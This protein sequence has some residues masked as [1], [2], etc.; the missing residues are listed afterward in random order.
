MDKNARLKWSGVA[1][2]ASSKSRVF[3]LRGA[4]GKGAFDGMFMIVPVCGCSFT[5]LACKNLRSY[6]PV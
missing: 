5:H 4:Y 1:K 2:I 6:A 3:F